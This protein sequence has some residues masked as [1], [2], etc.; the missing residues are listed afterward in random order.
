MSIQNQD[1][2]DVLTL[3]R[4]IRGD[5]RCQKSIERKCGYLIRPELWF[6]T[7][8]AGIARALEAKGLPVRMAYSN[9]E[10][11]AS[12]LHMIDGLE[13]WSETEEGILIVKD[14]NGIL[15][16]PTTYEEVLLA[17]DLLEKSRE[18][19]SDSTFGSHPKR[20]KNE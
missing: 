17:L 6:N 19:K 18:V 1:D 16:S 3:A 14:L 10:E 13:E 20:N 4:W 12:I 9:T 5:I 8:K 11:I 7:M 15:D 2:R